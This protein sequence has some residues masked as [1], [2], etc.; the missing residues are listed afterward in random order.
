M[1]TRYILTTSALAIALVTVQPAFAQF[2]MQVVGGP[3]VWGGHP[4]FLDPSSERRNSLSSTHPAALF[5]GGERSHPSSSLG[6]PMTTR[7]AVLP[8]SSVSGGVKDANA[9][10]AEGR[11]A[12]T[13]LSPSPSDSRRTPESQ[14]SLIRKPSAAPLTDG[15]SKP[16]MSSQRAGVLG[17]PGFEAQAAPAAQTSGLLTRSDPGAKDSAPKAQLPSAVS[18]TAPGPQPE[19]PNPKTWVIHSRPNLD[20]RNSPRSPPLPNNTAVSMAHDQEQQQ[21][22]ASGPQVSG[23]PAKTDLI[24]KVSAQQ[25]NMPD[26]DSGP[27]PQTE[28]PTPPDPNTWII[29]TRPNLYDRSSP[30][31]LQ[32]PSPVV[33]VNACDD[34]QREQKAPIAPALVVEPDPAP[35]AADAPQPTAAEAANEDP[36]RRRTLEQEQADAWDRGEFWTPPTYNPTGESNYMTGVR[37]DK[38]NALAEL[39]QAEQDR[40]DSNMPDDLWDQLHGDPIGHAR[41]I[42]M[43]RDWMIEIYQRAYVHAL[44]M[45]MTNLG[46]HAYAQIQLDAWREKSLAEFEQTFGTHF[47]QLGMAVSGDAFGNLQKMIAEGVP[48]VVVKTASRAATNVTEELAAN[49]PGAKATPARTVNPPPTAGENASILLVN[50]TAEDGSSLATMARNVKPTPGFHNVFMHGSAKTLAF[51]LNGQTIRLSVKMVKDAMIRTG[52]KGGAVIL[53]ACKTGCLDEGV[54][55]QLADELQ[56]SVMAPTSNVVLGDGTIKVVQGGEWR[57]FLPTLPATN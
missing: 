13:N 24:Q 39:R 50:E 42:I 48:V 49:A 54:A 26:P 5:G 21:P 19:S 25:V 28:T 15:S 30:P 45:G 46:A 27:A 14:T 4:M 9:M 3:Q 53:N 44:E 51:K 57:T 52:Y 32:S 6:S 36:P 41:E 10:R 17:A 47:A 7:T 11:T 16:S 55:Q 22:N 12:T 33:S 18:D 43:R 56:E 2:S 37:E 29:H 8:K 31:E 38:A 23:L 34:A 40:H 35:K 20:E 1:R